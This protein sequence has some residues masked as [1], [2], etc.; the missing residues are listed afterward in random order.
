[1]FSSA[2]VVFIFDLNC[3]DA[4]S[5]SENDSNLQKAAI[6]LS[7]L[8]LLTEF[9]AQTQNGSDVRWAS[10]FYDSLIFK[11][12]KTNNSFV[13]FNRLSYDTF[14]SEVS[15][16]LNFSTSH[17]NDS[18]EVEA[19]RTSQRN[20]SQN[21]SSR[22]IQRHSAC[23]IL[24]KAIQEAL[25]DYNWD[26]PD[27]SSPVITKKSHFAENGLKA[28][29]LDNFNAIVVF[30]KIPQ[31]AGAV[32]EFV[33]GENIATPEDFP[34]KFF[35]KATQQALEEVKGFRLFFID[36]SPTQIMF[37]DLPVLTALNE[38]L[39]K[40]N[41]SLHCISSIVDCSDLLS[42]S[43]RQKVFQSQKLLLHGLEK[44]WFFK[45]KNLRL[46]RPRKPQ[47]GPLLV[48]K[49]DS[50]IAA[51][52]KL[53]ILTLQGRINHEWQELNVVG[54]AKRSSAAVK[55]MSSINSQ[56][57]L[58][59][60]HQATDTSKDSIN[61]D[62][63][64]TTL[65]LQSLILVLQLTCGGI[66]LL[67][68][69]IGSV[70]CLTVLSSSGLAQ[71][72]LSQHLIE[73]SLVAIATEPLLAFTKAAI[74]KALNCG[75][76]VNVKA[77]SSTN[78]SIP[79]C[80]ANF[81]QSMLEP[82]YCPAALPK[83]DPGLTCRNVLS[84][85]QLALLNRA[86]RR[87]CPQLS[88][89]ISDPEVPTSVPVISKGSGA[90]VLNPKHAPLSQ[91]TAGAFS[92]PV[93]TVSRALQ[94]VNKSKIVTAQQKVKEQRD[95]EEEQE[96][97]QK[98]RALQ[99]SL[100][101]Q[102]S[103]AIMS[104][105]LS[106][107][108]DTTDAVTVTQSLINLRESVTGKSGVEND[109]TENSDIF[110]IAQTIINLALMHVRSASET[111]GAGATDGTGTTSAP[112][113]L[114]LR[115]V[116]AGVMLTSRDI[117]ALP[118]DYQ[119]Q[120][121]EL[122]TL[123][124]LETM[125]LMG[126]SSGSESS[127][128]TVGQ[129]QDRRGAEREAHIEEILRLLRGITLN[130]NPNTTTFF[131][132]QTILV[133]YEDTLPDVL[134]EIFEE[135]GQPVPPSL[136]GPLSVNT[137]ADTP[138]LQQLQSSQSSVMSAGSMVGSG[139]GGA[140]LRR[141]RSKIAVLGGGE[142]RQ[143][144]VPGSRMA[145]LTRASSDNVQGTNT[146]TKGKNNVRRS[147]FEG[148][149][150]G[151]K[152][153]QSSL[154]TPQPQKRR[155]SVQNSD[156]SSQGPA[157]VRKFSILP[158][159]EQRT[160]RRK[161]SYNR[162]EDERQGPKSGSEL[163]TPNKS[164]L[165][166][167]PITPGRRLRPSASA[168][169][170]LAPCTPSHLIGR[171]LSAMRR[172]DG[173]PVVAE[174]PE[175]KG[176]S[177]LSSQR[178]MTGRTSF[179]SGAQSRNCARAR[180]TLLA[181]RLQ[182]NCS[183][184]VLSTSLN[185]DSSQQPH[186]NANVTASSFLFSK[187]F[188]SASLATDAT[189][190][191]ETKLDRR[192]SLRRAL[193]FDQFENNVQLKSV[194][195]GLSPANRR[196][197]RS[198]NDEHTSPLKKVSRTLSLDSPLKKVTRASSSGT[199]IKSVRYSSQ[200]NQH[201]HAKSP[202]TPKRR[203]SDNDRL[204]SLESF[205]EILTPSKR[206]Q[207]SLLNTP[208]K[209]NT[210]ASCATTPKSILKTPTR[211]PQNPSCSRTPRTCVTPSRRPLLV[212]RTPRNHAVFSPDIFSCGKSGASFLSPVKTPAKSPAFPSSKSPARYTRDSGENF[213]SSR[214][215][216]KK[217][218]P[219]VIMS[220]SKGNS[221]VDPI[222]AI[223]PSPDKRQFSL[224]HRDSTDGSIA[225]PDMQ[226][227]NA[228]V[229][230]GLDLCDS[231]KESSS[232]KLES[233]ITP[234]SESL[235]T[236]TGSRLSKDSND[237]LPSN[238]SGLMSEIP[239][240]PDK[241]Q[242]TTL[243]KRTVCKSADAGVSGANV[244][245]TEIDPS[246]ASR[247][248]L[249]NSKSPVT[250]DEFFTILD[251]MTEE[252]I[253]PEEVPTLSANDMLFTR[254]LLDGQMCANAESILNDNL[255]LESNA[256]VE[257]LP[258]VSSQTN[259]ITFLEN[260]SL[261]AKD[262]SVTKTCNIQPLLDISAMIETDEQVIQTNDYW[263]NQEH[264]HET[265][266]S[267][268]EIEISPTIKNSVEKCLSA[269]T[270]GRHYNETLPPVS[271]SSTS[272]SSMVASSTPLSSEGRHSPSLETLHHTNPVETS[273]VPNLL[274]KSSKSP[275][276]T[277][278]KCMDPEDEFTRDGVDRNDAALSPQRLTSLTAEYTIKTISNETLGGDRQ[279]PSMDM[280]H[281]TKPMETS[282]V[283]NI[284]IESKSTEMASVSSL[285]TK[286]KITSDEVNP[287]DA[288]LSPK[289]RT[290]LTGESSVKT[291]RNATASDNEPDLVTENG[292]LDARSPCI[293][294]A[295]DF[296]E[297]NNV[298]EVNVIEA[299]TE[300][301]A[302]RN[303]RPATRKRRHGTD[304]KSTNG[305]NVKNSLRNTS[306][307]G[308]S[309][310]RRGRRRKRQPSSD[311]GSNFSIS[312]ISLDE[313]RSSHGLDR[314]S[315]S[316]SSNSTAPIIPEG[317]K[318]ERRKRQISSLLTND[319][320]ETSSRRISRSH[321]IDYCEEWNDFSDEESSIDE[322][323][324]L[325]KY[326]KVSSMAK[327][328]VETP[329][330]KVP[331]KN[332]GEILEK[333]TEEPEKENLYEM[334]AERSQRRTRCNKKL[335]DWTD[336]DDFDDIDEE[337]VTNKNVC[338]S[339][340]IDYCKRTEIDSDQELQPN[341]GSVFSSNS[342]E[343]D[344]SLGVTPFQNVANFSL[345]RRPMRN[346]AVTSYVDFPSDDSALDAESSLDGKQD[347]CS[348]SQKPPQFKIDKFLSSVERPRSQFKADPLVLDVAVSTPSDWKQTK[349]VRTREKLLEES[350]SKAVD[351]FQEPLE[352]KRYRADKKKR[353]KKKT[354]KL[355]FK[356]SGDEY[357]VS[358]SNVS[359]ESL[360]T[361]ASDFN[362]SVLSN[363]HTR[364]EGKSSEKKKRKKLNNDSF[365]TS[366]RF[367]RHMSKDLSITPEVFQKIVGA[368]PNSKAVRQSPMAQAKRPVP[369]I[370][371]VTSN[372]VKKPP[373]I[374]CSSSKKIENMWRVESVQGSPTL[375]TFIRVGGTDTPQQSP[376]SHLH[377]NLASPSVSSMLH[378]ATSPLINENKISSRNI[379][380]PSNSKLEKPDSSDDDFD[381]TDL[382]K[383]R[384]RRSS[385]F[386]AENVPAAK[387]LRSRSPVR[388]QRRASKRLYH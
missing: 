31:D 328:Y 45:G 105:A 194:T 187:I 179:Y 301:P 223:V 289:R 383:R 170:V 358:R 49:N 373:A 62:D 15:Q 207:F 318:T 115:E 285:D 104:S 263:L 295:V 308:A 362:S 372:S 79:G 343:C 336:I 3:L 151:L 264:N 290:S 152:R 337:S 72:P 94:L 329:R 221:R 349:P 375:K 198:F 254:S 244:N 40:F 278:I 53:E 320:P 312:D 195:L 11:P 261:Y 132:N 236:H 178:P 128:E 271:L 135:L 351:N 77:A 68:P 306:S 164:D 369:I 13:D 184:K 331:M 335:L 296:L 315:S 321:F 148:R 149:S 66:G 313:S 38:Y 138:P 208:S 23:F 211:A 281:H 228:T 361:T 324:Q 30:T 150:N 106:N 339:G 95:E 61:F 88:H 291:V 265:S 377:P 147:L 202:C 350:L 51:R 96:V 130:F 266:Y 302:S 275:E 256:Y 283:P 124:H 139:G 7:C 171:S 165:L 305:T 112:S 109:T 36:T 17:R 127:T 52:I 73:D 183:E 276:V 259:D 277:P 91:G 299:C 378:L 153:S 230:H 64:L 241:H 317:R 355:K 69:F 292:K 12:G 108:Q 279:S 192:R 93:K 367:T 176:E 247:F 35:E 210:N 154:V 300:Q 284:L 363:P 9:G 370:P 174:S 163:F 157:K 24:N 118:R 237:C 344:R 160:R 39:G 133:N 56:I 158:R 146:K 330:R 242:T 110:G 303:K 103:Q 280:P 251:R 87:C 209:A 309:A 255:K 48:W 122:H 181:Q 246:S 239:P 143:V 231:S 352:S 345:G 307:D 201:F 380:L 44:S 70:G 71:P 191:V 382:K 325:N 233:D 43:S 357:Q 27:V 269:L 332:K 74:K 386:D 47:P 249:R 379:S 282:L 326:G 140:V 8:R 145:R 41:G 116:L 78:S 82:W 334:P 274:N 119:L 200:K 297:N 248:I 175:L 214:I 42:N 234:K 227:N 359:G 46:G 90:T 85:M 232:D 99:S 185:C 76:G 356:K 83:P 225:S 10:K 327:R 262:L 63:L 368:S 222:H 353:V 156:D 388:V 58:C 75:K 360:D 190:N 267:S 252:S 385:S 121:Y 123:L 114:G 1:M 166:A 293:N 371:S 294:S 134:M 86:Q 32:Q 142:G 217:I 16:K 196:V 141:R 5:T 34:R 189:K 137:T 101:S 81:R 107:I 323:L 182:S 206:V 387:K 347:S 120:Q 257:R 136:A 342:L 366:L 204:I 129:E 65:H 348:L 203:S 162:Q 341:V 4:S 173:G 100:R 346:R 161:S 167:S 212:F 111:S 314:N 37:K 365:L 304:H 159:E 213:T 238:I 14:D 240:S 224:L 288:V 374:L 60:R 216:D 84:R 322:D 354:V 6:K 125:W 229:Y 131:L 98:R 92:K 102:K 218:T 311:A 364:S 25:K 268:P 168:G 20:A 67:S 197:T 193:N 338:S 272:L 219:F 316:S 80:S 28:G 19:R 50:K 235:G 340:K 287:N 319:K 243:K 54:Y 155:R 29:K 21:S 2:Q 245:G 273:L 33:G 57:M 177:V 381:F 226:E 113:G 26:L 215:R 270:L 298:D 22:A 144:F 172:S 199:P 126:Y 253:G 180:T 18:H 89:H 333:D 205:S 286:D 55:A 186:A 376:K 250:L 260:D 59:R 384:R 310:G 117:A 169:G 220:P 97:A 258:S 188:T